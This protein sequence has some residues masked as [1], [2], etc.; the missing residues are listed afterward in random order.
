MWVVVAVLIAATFPSL[1][2][3]GEDRDFRLGVKRLPRRKLLDGEGDDDGGSQPSCVCIFDVDGTI[4]LPGGNSGKGKVA[5][6]AVRVIRRCKDK[7]YGIAIASNS[8]EDDVKKILQKQVDGGIFNEG[9][10][11]SEAFQAGNLVKSTELNSILKFFDV[12]HPG[13]AMFFDDE[14][15]NEVFAILTGVTHRN[16][17]TSVGVTVAD[18]RSASE[19]VPSQCGCPQLKK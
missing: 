10:F 12:D 1:P 14:D 15:I 19:K 18:M 8:P 17:K 16:V 11:Q 3:A 6:E 4:W 7:G 5:G 9:F 13:C 2:S